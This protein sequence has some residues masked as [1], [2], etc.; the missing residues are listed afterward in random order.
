MVKWL[1]VPCAALLLGSGFKAR[2]DDAVKAKDPKDAKEKL[3]SS[4]L[5][6]G[7]VTAV[8][9]DARMLTIQVPLRYL[10]ANDDAVAQQVD[11]RQQLVDALQIEDAEERAQ[12]V[13]EVQAALLANE[14]NLVRVEETTLEVPI[15]AADDLKVRLAKLPPAFDDKG[16]PRKYTPQELKDLKGPGA[17][18][19]YTAA[20]SDLKEGQ[21]VRVSVARKKMTGKEIRD[22]VLAGQEIPL[23]AT[24][25]VIVA[26]PDE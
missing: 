21:I 2:A 19:G 15:R 16:N 13:Q 23:L 8:D 25:V 4:G 22:A 6:L 17:V 20:F 18:A 26:Q 14:A 11:L 3:I 1:L 12:R 7:R 24:V 10:V 5:L 9:A